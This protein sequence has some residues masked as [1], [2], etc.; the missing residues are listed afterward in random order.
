M[1]AFLG[2]LKLD[3]W[4]AVVF[5]VASVV[6]YIETLS[7]PAR[8]AEWPR[9]VLIAFGVL[10]LAVVLQRLIFPERDR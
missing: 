2:R 4:L 5:V 10:S 8:A 3:G 7:F 9:A 6:A 1:K